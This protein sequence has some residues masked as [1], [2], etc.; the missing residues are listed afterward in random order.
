LALLLLLA[1]C[2]DLLFFFSDSPPI[3]NDGNSDGVD[4]TDS[5]CSSVSA[6]E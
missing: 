6:G 1:L 5:S 2:A 3:E 4:V